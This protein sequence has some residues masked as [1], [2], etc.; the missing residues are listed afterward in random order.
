MLNSGMECITIKVSDPY[1]PGGKSGGG[2]DGTFSW[3]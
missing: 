3:Y 2:D 1:I